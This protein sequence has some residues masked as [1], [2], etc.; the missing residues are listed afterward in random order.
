MRTITFGNHK[1]S[2]LTFEAEEVDFRPDGEDFLIS[3]QGRITF[4]DAPAMEE[5]MAQGRYTC[6]I[7]VQENDEELLHDRYR[8]T[9][10]VLEAEHFVARIEKED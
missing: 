2:F 9:F 10:L 1:R 3:A 6:L 4:Q 7:L 8:V 5:I